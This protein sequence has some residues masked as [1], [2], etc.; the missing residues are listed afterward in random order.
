MTET[1]LPMEPV[2][3]KAQTLEATQVQ[4]KVELRRRGSGENLFKKSRYISKLLHREALTP[5]SSQRR[6]DL[7]EPDSRDAGTAKS[8]SQTVNVK[9]PQS[10]SLQA[11]SLKLFDLLPD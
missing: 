5:L 2:C 9:I 1:P 11:F 8:R 4:H 6:K 10:Q 3:E 7:R